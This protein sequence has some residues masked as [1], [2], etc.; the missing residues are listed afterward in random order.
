M[1]SKRVYFGKLESWDFNLG[2][3]SRPRDSTGI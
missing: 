1:S 2:R 3:T